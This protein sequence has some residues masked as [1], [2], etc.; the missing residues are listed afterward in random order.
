MFLPR[1]FSRFPR[2]FVSSGALWW[3]SGPTGYSVSCRGGVGA[4][5]ADPVSTGRFPND[6]NFLFVDV[7]RW[8]RAPRCFLLQ[9]GSVGLGY[10]VSSDDARPGLFIGR[11]GKFASVRT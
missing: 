8:L 5:E 9:R 10:F 11:A 4:P 2:N 6:A 7:L 3:G 1:S